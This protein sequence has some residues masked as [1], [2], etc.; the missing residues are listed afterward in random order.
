MTILEC[1]YTLQ[2]NC[3]KVV[4][5]WELVCNCWG[6]ELLIRTVLK[7]LRRLCLAGWGRGLSE[8]LLL[9]SQGCRDSGV[10]PRSLPQ[11]AVFQ[12]VSLGSWLIHLNSPDLLLWGWLVC[13]CVFSGLY[14]H[15][16]YLIWQNAIH[17]CWSKWIDPLTINC[18][19]FRSKVTLPTYLR[20]EQY[21]GNQDA[22]LG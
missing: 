21:Q 18:F 16:G 8:P 5:D 11:A 4:T 17:P 2:L 1:G 19:L 20:S 6:S 9:H 12:R 15:N 13:G 22:G 10:C 7:V 14:L 3:F